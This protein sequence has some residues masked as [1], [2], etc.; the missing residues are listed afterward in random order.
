MIVTQSNFDTLAERYGMFSSWAIWN[1]YDPAD[2]Q[3]IADHLN[4]LKTSVVL[5]GLNVSARVRTHWQ[6]F[7]GCP[8]DRKLMFAFNHSPYRGAY[9]PDIIKGEIEA[10][11]HELLA[12]I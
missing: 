7:H 11:S 2:S 6:N 10:S 5:T 12:R 1:P 8:H 4:S 9:M 3:I